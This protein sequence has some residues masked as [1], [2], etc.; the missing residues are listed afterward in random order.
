M[1]SK[2]E[3]ERE[4]EMVAIVNQ[5]FRAVISANLA[6]GP[7]KGAKRAVKAV[8]KRW[9]D[10]G[11]TEEEVARFEATDPL[12]PWA[13]SDAA[14]AARDAEIERQQLVA[15]ERHQARETER[16]IADQ[17][18]D[19]FPTLSADDLAAYVAD[20]EEAARLIADK[21]R[22]DRA[23]LLKRARN[24]GVGFAPELVLTIEDLDN[25]ADP[26]WLIDELIPEGVVG[27]LVGETGSLKSTLALD[28]GCSVAIGVPAIGELATAGPRRVLFVAGEGA[29]GLRRRVAAYSAH[30]RL[31]LDARA[32]MARNINFW[33]RPVNLLAVDDVA[34]VK[35]FVDAGEFDLVILDTLST[36]TAGMDENSSGD[37]ADALRAARY[38]VEGRPTASA[39]VL[40]HPV[41]GGGLDGRGSG[42]WKANLDVMLATERDG[43][44][45][46]LTVE[47]SKDA[48]TGVPRILRKTIVELPA[49]T[50]SNGTRH[51]ATTSVVVEVSVLG[52]GGIF[53]RKRGAVDDPKKLAAIAEAFMEV[54]EGSLANGDTPS[55]TR[56]KDDFRS[57]AKSRHEWA[58]L[59]FSNGSQKVIAEHL[60]REGRITLGVADRG[61]IRVYRAGVA[62]PPAVTPYELDA[63]T[64]QP[65]DLLPLSTNNH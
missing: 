56:V 51:S 9:R 14:R 49:A 5:T 61:S 26:K 21:R 18:R 36:H 1:P 4:V 32:L 23:A 13:L 59:G 53:G 25:L 52:E 28:F 7:A 55:I 37:M 35:A 57:Q 63:P 33:D 39:L 44:L 60:A 11:A 17:L 16:E 48:A 30:R 47:K 50:S 38:L 40:H 46:R 42:A 29:Q 12:E 45:V 62:L 15:D 8:R 3:R 2:E 34:A 41:K 31:D 54:I 24:V 10:L 20:P 22:A 6:D 19:E 64:H 43:D 58:A 65:L 27:G